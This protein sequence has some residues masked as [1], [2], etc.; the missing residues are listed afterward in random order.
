MK[1]NKN[2][3]ISQHI[4]RLSDQEIH[5]TE[6]NKDIFYSD[7]MTSDLVLFSDTINEHWQKING[8][9]NDV[10]SVSIIN[11]NEQSRLYCIRAKHCGLTL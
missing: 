3:N 6:V 8:K 2:Y 9:F 5:A 4:S 10:K 7:E 11:P 1:N